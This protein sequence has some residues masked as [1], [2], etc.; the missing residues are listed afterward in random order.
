MSLTTKVNVINLNRL[1]VLLEMHW[2]LLNLYHYNTH[3]YLEG[4]V[5]KVICKRV[6]LLTGVL[7]FTST[8]LV[9]Y[10]ILR[11]RKTTHMKNLLL[12][13]SMVFFSGGYRHVVW[14]VISLANKNYINYHQVVQISPFLEWLEWL[15]LC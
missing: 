1:L 4:L 2:Q 14:L 12:S 3:I 6:S 5:L 11:D 9:L 7:T 15:H 10:I 13:M 8:T